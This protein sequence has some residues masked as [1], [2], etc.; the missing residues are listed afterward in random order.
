MSR[1]RDT[2]ELAEETLAQLELGGGR[3]M[4]V[5]L[6][7]LR[8]A[9]LLNNHQAEEWFRLELRGYRPGVTANDEWTRYAAWSG[10]EASV[11]AEGNQLYWTDPIEMIEAQLQIAQ[12]DLSALHLPS[13]SVS[14]TGS[15]EGLYAFTKTASEKILA[16]VIM[17]RT[18]K[19][20]ELRKWNKIVS[21]T[22]G[23]IEDWLSTVVTE[24][25][26]G[27]I[28]ET[29]FE[30]ARSR[31]DELLSRHSPETSRKLAAA[32]RRADSSDPEE[33]SQALT[34]CRRALK[35]LADSL[36]PPTDEQPTGHPLGDQEYRN[37]LIQFVKDKSGSQSQTK[38]ITIEIERVADRVE[39]LDSLASKGVHTDVD[40]R[41]LELTI[42][43]T[44]LLAGQ[45]LELLPV[46]EASPVEATT[47]QNTE[48][49][50]S[51]GSTP[52]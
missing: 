33:W 42:V 49:P 48:P 23:A 4:P 5:I 45:L 30:R 14:D 37:R 22:R 10:R 6:K 12:D 46:E 29:A 1:T 19:A 13:I 27:A 39:A 7:C 3:L 31:F 26:Y 21:C 8:L 32:Y 9:R 18:F 20:T 36:Y 2:L 25:R 44:Y 24:L 41:D 47:P 38:F 51:A 40:V 28:V 50:E 43:H 35:A 11:N 17:K 34:S 15:V 16:A 52:E